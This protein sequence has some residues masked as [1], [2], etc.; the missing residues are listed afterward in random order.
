ME[1]TQQMIWLTKENYL[2]HLPINPIAFSVAE[3]GA[4]GCPGIVIIVDEISNMYLFDLYAMGENDIKKIIPTF[5]E[6][7]FSVF[8]HD[9]SAPHWNRRYLGC[10]NHLVVAD[11]IYEEFCVIAD[12]RCKSMGDLY[13]QWGDIVLEIL[14]SK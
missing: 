12:S 4:M 7:D 1:Q 3:G 13:N 8:G 5:F 11:S 2:Q 14:H 6:F 10:G 9:K